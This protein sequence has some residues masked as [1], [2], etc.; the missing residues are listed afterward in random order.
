MP[1]RARLPRENEGQRRQYTPRWDAW[2][3]RSSL[4]PR[5]QEGRTHLKAAKYSASP[6]GGSRPPVKAMLTL[7]PTPGPVPTCTRRGTR[8]ADP[9]SDSTG[10]PTLC[11]PSRSQAPRPR[12]PASLPPTAERF[13]SA[14]LGN[15]G[16]W[17]ATLPGL[18]LGEGVACRQR[19]TGDSAMGPSCPTSWRER[20]PDA[21]AAPLVGFRLLGLP[22]QREGLAGALGVMWEPVVL[23]H[24]GDP[25]G[26][27]T[28][29]APIQGTG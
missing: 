12:G 19:V 25:P 14:G 15:V 8:V 28:R 11:A 4:K 7:K 21:E 26:E 2:N 16:A 13:R 10:P 6:M 5:G 9:D 17:A 27:R 18:Q 20:G 23:G 3:S 22:P 24:R 1:G 29:P